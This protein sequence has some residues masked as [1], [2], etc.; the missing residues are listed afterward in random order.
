MHHKGPEVRILYKNDKKV[1]L[2]IYNVAILFP[3]P[4]K[5]IRHIYFIVCLKLTC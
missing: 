5:S 4:I 1:L 3:F 2:S